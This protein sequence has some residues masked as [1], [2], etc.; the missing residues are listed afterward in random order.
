MRTPTPHDIAVIGAGPVGLVTAAAFA[1]KGARVL[2]LEANAGASRRLAGEWLHPPGVEAL[3]RLDLLP[4]EILAGHPA[5]RGFAVFPDDASEAIVLPYAPGQTALTADHASLV[6]ALRTRVAQRPGVDYREGVRVNGLVSGGLELQGGERVLAGLVVGADGRKSIVRRALGIDAP[7]RTLSNMAGVELRLPRAGAVELPFEGFGHVL[8]GGPGPILMYR[9][10]PDRVRVCLDIPTG[11]VGARRDV[12]YLYE[13]FSL[14]MPESLRPAFREALLAGRVQWAL[15]RFRPRSFYGRGEVALVGDAVGST[16]PLT[17]AGMTLGFADALCLA[18]AQDVSRYAAQREQASYVPELLA[19]ALYQVFER[20]DAS[21]EAIRQTV[22]E[23]WRKSDFERARTM[24]LLAGEEVSLGE[25]GAAFVKVAGKAV[26]RGFGVAGAKRSWLG[27]WVGLEEWARW[28]AATLVPAKLRVR[29]RPRSS[30]VSPFPSRDA[31]GSSP[32][33]SARRGSDESRS[34]FESSVRAG[35]ASATDASLRL[36]AARLGA[37]CSEAAPEP[38]DTLSARCARLRLSLHAGSTAELAPELGALLT[39]VPEDAPA[40]A[41]WLE[42]LADA[43]RHA[44]GLRTAAIEQVLNAARARQLEAP[45]PRL[46]T[47]DDLLRASASLRSSAAVGLPAFHPWVRRRVFALCAALQQDAELRRDLPPLVLFAAARAILECGAPRLDLVDEIITRSVELR[48]LEAAE[49]ALLEAA[50]VTLTLLNARDA[51]GPLAS[52]RAS[53]ADRALT[54]QSLLDV[55]RT[56]ARPIEMLPGDLETAVTCG[57]LLCRVA[58]TIEDNPN[59]A[60]SARDLRYGVF[61]DVIEGR[62]PASHFEHLWDDVPGRA[63]ELHLCKNLGAVMRVFGDLPKGMRERTVPWVAEMTRGMQLYSHRPAGDD[64]FTALL[65][66]D[67]LSRYCYYVA[68]TVGH[69]L[70]DLFLEALGADVSP[71]VANGLREH[72]EGFGL[73]LQLTNILKDVTDDAERLCSFIPRTVCAREGLGIAELTD[74]NRRAAAH[75]AVAPLFD[76]AR[77]RLDQALEY[78]LSLPSTAAEMRLFCLLPLFMAVRTLEHARGNDA[79][80]VADAPV[81][82]PRKEVEALIAD[83]V[84][85]VRDDAALRQRY[86]A[87][88]LHSSEASS[89][90]EALAP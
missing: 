73:G 19:S 81:K 63:T 64:G 13:A 10:G 35:L 77:Q 65:T 46:D 33:P 53:A 11:C 38:D 67:D 71:D 90:Q 24:R 27:E 60:L 29:F 18:E 50:A 36:A 59:L 69:M 6:R 2:L 68:G 84:M 45:R 78:T 66:E 8:L 34:L 47:P 7:T 85:H 88:W 87:L 74:P 48:S 42:A 56:F 43:S 22:Y 40:E 41:D 79:M 9:I 20:E 26:G 61:L 37:S 15:G 80:F 62:A 89:R 75:R 21:A 86:A 76:S 4:E 23:V 57:Y 51:E 28:P 70:T 72:A 55:S 39:L 12:A 83:C 14:R 17:A 16:H 82:I 30:D 54:K 5:G 1:R 49:P 58:D 25:F 44:P 32:A 52:R 31:E 3:R